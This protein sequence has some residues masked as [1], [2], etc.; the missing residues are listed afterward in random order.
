MKHN[1]KT[2]LDMEIKVTF[3]FDASDSLLACV[4]NFR[5]AAEAFAQSGLLSQL[6]AT[7]EA[8]IVKAIATEEGVT[9]N[10][11]E[12]IWPPKEGGE[13]AAAAEPQPTEKGAGGAAPQEEAKPK[14][15]PQPEAAAPVPTVTDMRAAVTR[16]R[17]RIEGEGWEDKTSDGYKLWHK[18][19]TA[20]VKN[21][22]MSLGAEK[23]PDIA[24]ESRRSFVE[25]VDLLGVV[26]NEVMEQPPF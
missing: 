13:G 25:E 10:K 3:R 18:K 7:K 24:E 21:I 12:Q 20:A 5:K 1:P 8:G 4:D 23:I 26:G 17:D 11:K 2:F 19:V 22:V 16:A 14:E 9:M 15:E 6:P